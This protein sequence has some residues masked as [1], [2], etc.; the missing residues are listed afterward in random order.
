MPW[1]LE[2][3]QL[4]ECWNSWGL[5]RLLVLLVERDVVEHQLQLGMA[6]RQDPLGGIAK[7]LA[8]APTRR[9]E[10]FVDHPVRLTHNYWGVVFSLV[11]TGFPFAFLLTLSYLT[12]IDPTLERAASTLGAGWWQRFRSYRPRKPGPRSCRSWSESYLRQVQQ[13]A[14]RRR[15]GRRSRR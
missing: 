14:W 4:G 10:W 2:E 8:V 11:I 9:G 6:L 12:G 15:A 5:N 13:P 3:Q 7:V 1:E